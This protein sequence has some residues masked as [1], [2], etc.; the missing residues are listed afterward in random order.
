MGTAVEFVELWRGDILESVHFGHAVVCNGAGEAVMAW[1]D[2]DLITYPR[3][4]AK[5]IQA[6]PLVESGAADMVRLGEEQLALAC[7]SHRGAA[8][9]TTRVAAWLQGLGLGE[10]DLRCGSHMPS[11]REAAESLVRAAER[12]CQIHN[13]CSGKHAGF[14]TLTRHLGAGPEY[15]EIDHPVQRAARAAFEETSGETSAGWGVD[16]CSAPNF[17]A[18]LTGIARAMASFATAGSRGGARAE[19]QRRLVAAMVAHPEL[20][21][22]E[23]AACA[24]LMRA[25]GGRAAVKTGA[26]GVY[27]GILPDLGLGVALKI[28]DGATRASEAVIAALLVRLGVL[29]AGHPVAQRLSSGEQRNW[30]GIPTG[31]IVTRL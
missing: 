29:E 12:P 31:R 8:M 6:L 26:E 20:V 19:A 5:M 16:G 4:S 1:G 2:P 22:G 9:H 21:S 28:A 15:V 18:S 27:V 25:C 10:G 30:R 23:G 11:D 17:A 13:N 24:A 3:S 7:A 14:L